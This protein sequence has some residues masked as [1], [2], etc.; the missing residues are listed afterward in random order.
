MLCVIPKRIIIAYGLW[1][2]KKIHPYSLLKGKPTRI[3]RKT[4]P[5]KVEKA[6]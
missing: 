5:A 6:R 2:L 4:S 3:S 1:C